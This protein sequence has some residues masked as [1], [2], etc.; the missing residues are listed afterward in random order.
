MRPRCTV[1]SWGLSDIGLKRLNNEDVFIAH[2]DTNFYALADGMGG[3][4]A[5]E[6]AAQ[7]AVEHLYAQF[8]DSLIA[9]EKP[10]TDHLLK[11]LADTIQEVNSH[12]YQMA[13]SYRDWSGM[14]TT[15]SCLFLHDQKILYAHVGDSRIYRF[16]QTLEQL[17]HDHSLRKEFPYDPRAKNKLTRAIGTSLFVNPQTGIT[18]FLPGDLYL[19]CS[20]GLTDLVS[21]AE[22]TSHIVQQT[23]LPLLCHSL[24]NAAKNEGGHDNITVIAVKILS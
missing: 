12:V 5:G 24:V 7:L 6:I 4:Q 3:H 11:K 9:L 8:F 20:D 16:R 15:L 13:S 23:A 18:D 1:E 21:D 14:G 17:S 2:N 22:I 19:L 10:S